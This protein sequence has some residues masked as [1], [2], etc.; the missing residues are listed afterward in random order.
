MYL[1]IK[2]TQRDENGNLGQTII[3][4]HVHVA[5]VIVFTPINKMMITFWVGLIN[6]DLY[7]FIH[8]ESQWSLL[9]FLRGTSHSLLIS[10]I[11]C[12]IFFSFDSCCFLIWLINLA[13]SNRYGCEVVPLNS[14]GPLFR[15]HEYF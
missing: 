9:F 8:L 10:I 4:V 5:I 3:L 12:T 6:A 2:A 1:L 15:A 11:Y 14:R 13:H 7:D